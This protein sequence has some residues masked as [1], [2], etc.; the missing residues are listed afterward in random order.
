MTYDFEQ[1]R[2]HYDFLTPY[3]EQAYKRRPCRWTDPYSPHIDWPKMFSPIEMVTWGCLRSFGRAPLYPQYPVGRYFTDFGHPAAKIALECDGKE[4]HKDKEKDFNRDVE[5]KNMGW[6]VYRISGADCNRVYEPFEELRED[7]DYTP[8]EKYG[9]LKEYF[10]TTVDGLIRAIAI[11]HFGFISY[12]HREELQIAY[13]CLKER[14]SIN[15]DILDMIY[16]EKM[17]SLDGDPF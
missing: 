11:F 7:N 14:I 9:I 5:F 12:M 1:I 6:I 3:I 17:L 2:K 8:E 13:R 16:E 4:W 15:D 10:T